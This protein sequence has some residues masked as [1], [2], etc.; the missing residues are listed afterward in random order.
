ME[1]PCVE[2]D[3]CTADSECCDGKVC[4]HGDCVEPCDPPAPGTCSD[5]KPCCDGKVC[6]HG[7]CVTPCLAPAPGQCSDKYPCCDG[8]ICDGHGNC[9]EPCSESNPCDAGEIC[10]KHGLC[11]PCP[12]GIGCA[13]CNANGLGVCVDVEERPGQSTCGVTCNAVCNA[14]C[15][16]TGE[17]NYQES[18]CSNAAGG[19]CKGVFSVFDDTVDFMGGPCCKCKTGVCGN[20]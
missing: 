5:D 7:D 2:P 19:N 18:D 3:T 10:D 17:D 11:V 8:K 1:C 9:V 12:D 16:T 14:V 6:E 15:G 20:P 13:V 4:E